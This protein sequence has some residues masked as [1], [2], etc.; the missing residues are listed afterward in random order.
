MTE[1][2]VLFGASKSLVGVVSDP[3]VGTPRAEVACIFLNAGFTQHIGP[4]RVYVLIARRLA[5]A[6]MV[7]L[8]FDYSGIGDSP[9]RQDN[10]AFEDSTIS[11]AQEAMSFLEATRGVRQF[12]LMGICWGADNSLRVAMADPRVV[13]AAAVDFYALPSVRNLVRSHRARLVDPRSWLGLLRGQSA[14]FG[15]IV[16]GVLDAARRKMSR[17][18]EVNSDGIMPVKSPA[19][20]ASEL[21]E[22]VDRG[23]HLCLIYAQGAPSYDQFCMHFRGPMRVLEAAGG[24]R[25][26]MFPQADHVFTLLRNQAGL[27][28]VVADWAMD[29]AARRSPADPAVASVGT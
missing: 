22:V 27:V 3:S 18:E 23:T 16:G 4:Q 8:R 21:G 26:E 12:V 2:A 28:D 29:V 25:L 7:A 10:M 13:G 15:R 20:I 5:A 1:A 24:L 6:G 17:V 9:G 19:A 11:E 14:A